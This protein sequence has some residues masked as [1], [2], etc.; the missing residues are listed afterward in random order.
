[1]GISLPKVES[2]A[3]KYGYANSRVKAM[4]GLLLDRSSLDE[5]IR[6]RTVDGMIELLQRTTYRDD[7]LGEEGAYTGSQIVEMASAKN[8]S[9][10]VGKILRFTPESDLPA[11][12]ALLRKWDILNMKTLIHA[13]MA[14]L[15][16]KDVKPYLFDVGGLPETDA[17]RIMKAEG[18]ELFNELKKTELGKEMLSVSTAEFS[19]H[20]RMVFNNALKNMNMFVQAESIIDAYTYLFMDKG[21]AEVGGK[22]VK[23]I[24]RILKKEIDEKNILIIERLKKYNFSKD[25]IKRYLIRGGTLR[26]SF[27]DKLIEAQDMQL[28]I[29]LIKSRFRKLEVKESPS[30]VD[31]DM[32]LEKA[33]A[34]E[35]TAAFHRSILSVGVVLGFILLKETEMHN[36]R[37][38]AKAKEFN[39]PEAEVREMLVIV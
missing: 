35:K 1:M 22:E 10:T 39:I 29:S 2:K 34:A 8:F 38:I 25:E 24:R 12:K 31:L 26:T 36:L 5:M 27:I 33:L 11:V 13:K 15:G 20:M 28:T 30:L 14:G 37:K 7:F 6:V 18:D 21:L 4:K 3:L 19:K 9:K 17:E 23:S 32:A 16:Y